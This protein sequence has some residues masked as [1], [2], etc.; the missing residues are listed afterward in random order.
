MVLSD[1]LRLMG[2]MG[3]NACGNVTNQNKKPNQLI[4]T[5]NLHDDI[6][7]LRAPCKFGECKTNSLTPTLE[8]QC[9]LIYTPLTVARNLIQSVM[10]YICLSF[11]FCIHLK[12]KTMRYAST[13]TGHATSIAYMYCV[14]CV[15]AWYTKNN[16]EDEYFRNRLPSYRF[17][18]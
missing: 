15:R 10:C 9:I 17:N 13:C 3:R 16:G 6:V 7:S 8:C 5:C 18:L 11:A 12:W 1:Q 4:N 14:R 2:Y